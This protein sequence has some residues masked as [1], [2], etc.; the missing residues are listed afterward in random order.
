MTADVKDGA[1]KFEIANWI[2]ALTPYSGDE[3]EVWC[4]VIVWA[5]ENVDTSEQTHSVAFS[6]RYGWYDPDV[7]QD[8]VENFRFEN[9]KVQTPEYL[10][11]LLAKRPG[12]KFH[13]A[14]SVEP[15]ECIGPKIFPR[16]R[17]CEIMFW[18]NHLA[19]ITDPV[20]IHDFPF[21]TQDFKI[22]LGFTSSPH[23]EN[24]GYFNEKWKLVSHRDVKNMASSSLSAMS[25]NNFKIPEYS[26][27]GLQPEAWADSDGWMKNSGYHVMYTT[28]NNAEGHGSNM[29]FCYLTQRESFYY[30]LNVLSVTTAVSTLMIL[31][32]A[33]DPGDLYDRL[34]YDITILLTVIALKFA[35]SDAIPVVPYN[36]MLDWKIFITSM[37]VFVATM[38][39]GFVGY[40]GRKNPENDNV[41]GIDDVMGLIWLVCALLSEGGYWSVA[42]HKAKK[43]PLKYFEE[44]YTN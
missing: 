2:E 5:V 43:S 32:F 38:M 15:G 18:H 31:S 36:T 35:Y 23:D 17:G 8:C 34:A 27:S 13:N 29:E 19:T 30:I 6:L 33:G 24:K 41:E 9:S 3:N 7:P 40:Y 1:D 26:L 20:Q 11:V 25:V 21:D 42:M 10:N 14:K 39:H 4:R 28:C 16:E 44:H 37:L 22:T 12:F